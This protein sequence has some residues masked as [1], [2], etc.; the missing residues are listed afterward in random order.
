MIRPIPFAGLLLAPVLLMSAVGLRTAT[1]SPETSLPIDF[2]F[3]VREEVACRNFEWLPADVD[4]PIKLVGKRYMS[5]NAGTGCDFTSVERKNDQ[6]FEVAMACVFFMGGQHDS[7]DHRVTFRLLGAGRVEIA[8]S[9]S[10]ITTSVFR[11]C[12]QDQLPEPFSRN[13]ISDRLR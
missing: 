13:D 8:N 10:V 3:Y 11:Y 7:F 6:L 12:P 5:L 1:A 2:G 9:G 4:P